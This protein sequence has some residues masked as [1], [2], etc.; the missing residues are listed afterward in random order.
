MPQTYVLDTH[1]LIWYFVG[2]DQ[3]RSRQKEKIEEVRNH[4]GRLLIPTI[5]LAEA[6]DVAEKD[7]VEFD[8]SSMYELIQKHESFEIIG[9]SQA[10]FEKTRQIENI[11]GIHDRIIAATASFYE[12]GVMTKDEIIQDSGEIET[13]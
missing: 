9:F 5:V 8:F 10:I 11:I 2:S 13:L 7:R 1:V 3:L 4:G 6:L 12:S